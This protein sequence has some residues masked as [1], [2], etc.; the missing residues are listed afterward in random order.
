MW[1]NQQFPAGLFLF[2]EEIILDGKLHFLCI[3]SYRIVLELLKA[4]I[5]DR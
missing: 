5:Q 3:E 2:T 1:A 4:I